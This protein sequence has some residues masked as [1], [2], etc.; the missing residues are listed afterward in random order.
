MDSRQG[1]RAAFASSDRRLD[2][3]PCI[4]LSP[5]ADRRPAAAAPVGKRHDLAKVTTG[6]RMTFAP[7]ALMEVSIG[8]G[9]SIH[10]DCCCRE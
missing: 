3:S 10:V 7:A 9:E 1:S 2:R 5:D 4:R 6:R 8:N